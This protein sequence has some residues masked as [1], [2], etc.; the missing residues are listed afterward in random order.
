M[1]YFILFILMWLAPMISFHFILTR[2]DLLLMSP[3]E[4]LIMPYVSIAIIIYLITLV[5]TMVRAARICQTNQNKVTW[6]G[7][8]SG[9]K[10]GFFTSICG[11]LMYLLVEMYPLLTMPFLA[12]SV[13]PNATN[14]GKGFY[15]ALG[16]FIA[17]WFGRMFV[18]LC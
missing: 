16:G 6:W 9:L 2:D 1:E 3:I 18:G 12:I 17:Y 8:F 15:V 11:A 5:I 4:S 7:F 13:L 10:L 14:I